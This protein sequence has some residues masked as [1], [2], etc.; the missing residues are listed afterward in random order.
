MSHTVVIGNGIGFQQPR[1]ISFAQ[2][3]FQQMETD[4]AGLLR[5][6]T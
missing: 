6:T 3:R 4:R 5:Y 2:P 1:S